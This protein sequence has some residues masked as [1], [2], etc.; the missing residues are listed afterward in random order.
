MFADTLCITL[1]LTFYGASPEVLMCL[2]LARMYN[3]PRW[4]SVTASLLTFAELFYMTEHPVFDEIPC[5]AAHSQSGVHWHLG[6]SCTETTP[7]SSG[8]L[9][10]RSEMWIPGSMSSMKCMFPWWE[11]RVV[12]IIFPSPRDALIHQTVV[13]ARFPNK[14]GLNFCRPHC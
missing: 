7:H 9:C 14:Y 1:E 4:S 3:L 13:Q 2:V 5:F 10:S 12:S 11:T 8:S 6:L